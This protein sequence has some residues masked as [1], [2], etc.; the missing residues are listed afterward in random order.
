MR[1]R[2]IYPLHRRRHLHR[3]NIRQIDRNSLIVT[4]HK[5]TLKRLVLIR[6]DLL[7]R[8]IRRD[9]DEVA[10][11][12]FRCELELLAPSIIRQRS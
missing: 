1:M 7:M 10:R 11:S 5:H 2:R 3:L 4:P 6:V 9:E 12:C 8:H